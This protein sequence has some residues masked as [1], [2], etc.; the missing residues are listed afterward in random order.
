MAKLIGVD[1]VV[2]PFEMQCFKYVVQLAKT[3]VSFS[4]QEFAGH[5]D[6]YI[7]TSFPAES[8]SNN[9]IFFRDV[10]G[11]DRQIVLDRD[12]R[13]WIDYRTGFYYLCF[14]ATTHY[15]AQIRVNEQEY[16]GV[17][18]LINEQTTTS[19]IPDGKSF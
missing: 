10:H 8:P 6:T 15:S 17:F 4:I 7:I 12:I 11:P 19:V 3:D 5:S 13:K 9:Y 14:Y 1:V 16:F 2:N 18:V